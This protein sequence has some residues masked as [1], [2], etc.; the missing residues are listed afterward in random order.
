VSLKIDK[1]VPIPP[2]AK[3]TTIGREDFARLDVGDSFAVPVPKAY[4]RKPTVWA[5]TQRLRN[6]AYQYGRSTGRK[7]TVRCL[8]GEI[9]IWRVA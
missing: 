9:R 5:G 7:F 8:N 6:A 3:K 4:Q 1:G 2:R